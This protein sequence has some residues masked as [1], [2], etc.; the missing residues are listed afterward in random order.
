MVLQFLVFLGCFNF[1]CG[2]FFGYGKSINKYI[3]GNILI[4][5][6]F[7]SF[8]IILSLKI[9]SVDIHKLSAACF[10][11]DF[12]FLNERVYVLEHQFKVSDFLLIL[13]LDCVFLL[14]HLYHLVDF[15]F[16]GNQS[17]ILGF[18]EFL[19]F[20][21]ED[22][23][24]FLNIHWIGHLFVFLDQYFILG[25][26]ILTDRE[27][28]NT[29][30]HMLTEE[31]TLPVLL[32]HLKEVLLLFELLYER[33]DLVH[34]LSVFVFLHGLQGLYYV[35]HHLNIH[36]K[37]SRNDLPI[38]SIGYVFPNLIFLSQCWQLSIRL[39]D[40]TFLFE[41]DCWTLS[42]SWHFI[43]NGITLVC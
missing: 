13:K 3:Q 41:G 15:L 42:Q 27:E 30:L 4:G 1:L 35:G 36:Q 11:G 21:L 7:S 33:P 43:Q 5:V 24:V 10:Q 19:D 18:K 17:A 29:V 34:G 20:I 8:N 2:Y 9:S 6:W 37:P 25:I 14:I 28:S 23:H 39:S 12:T 40:F 38:I 22:C 26:I 31:L 32:V 16:E